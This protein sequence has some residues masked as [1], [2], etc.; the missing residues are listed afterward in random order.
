MKWTYKL[1]NEEKD[2]FVNKIT[3]WLSPVNGKVTIDE[4]LKMYSTVH[5]GS[6]S[7][8]WTDFS[9]A[10]NINSDL[11]EYK[12]LWGF[13]NKE[14]FESTISDAAWMVAVEYWFSKDAGNFNSLLGS[15]VWGEKK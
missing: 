3:E 9:Y 12:Y 4:P 11:G 8:E 5:N 15:K 13:T 1:T 14:L 7:E 6:N 10:I 2:K